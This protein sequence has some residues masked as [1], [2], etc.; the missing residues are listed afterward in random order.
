[1]VPEE[2]SIP[3]V[4]TTSWNPKQLVNTEERG[5]G[6]PNDLVWTMSLSQLWCHFNSLWFCR[7]A[8]VTFNSSLL[9]TI[10]GHDKHTDGNNPRDST[11]SL[12]KLFHQVLEE[13]PKALDGAIGENLY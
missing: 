1:M 8:E 13:D 9:L 5:P 4:M 7:A 11:V 10:K 3:P 6:E 12:L 2:I